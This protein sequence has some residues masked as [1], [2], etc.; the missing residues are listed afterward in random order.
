[1]E[2]ETRKNE[3]VDQKKGKLLCILVCKTDTFK[4]SLEAY[5]PCSIASPFPSE[6]SC[7]SFPGGEEKANK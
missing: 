2:T 3:D 5:I 6:A 4:R 1:M 7:S